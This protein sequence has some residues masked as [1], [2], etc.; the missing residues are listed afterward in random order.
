MGD[1]GFNLETIQVLEPLRSTPAKT[2]VLPPVRAH[3]CIEEA[4]EFGA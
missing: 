4:V 1:P 3:R 2:I